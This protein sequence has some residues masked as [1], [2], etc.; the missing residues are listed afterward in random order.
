[1]NIFILSLIPKECAQ[2]HC[3]KHCVKMILEYAQLLSCAHHILDEEKAIQ[4]IYKKTHVNHPCAIWT[5]KTDTNY[6]WLYSLFVS[7][8]DEY[9]HRYNKIHL[10]DTKMRTLLKN[11]PKNIPSGSLTPFALAMP[12]MYKRDCAIKSYMLYYIHSKRKNKRD[13]DMLI[14]TNREIPYFL[15]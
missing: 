7:L 3:D 13:K 1:M 10:T 11:K 14:Y 2:M 4:G 15:Q 6:E 9:T 8:C 5:R 12:N